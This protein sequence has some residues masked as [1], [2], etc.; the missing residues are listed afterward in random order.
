ML[1][2][3]ATHTQKQ[4]KKEKIFLFSSGDFCAF[5]FDGISFGGGHTALRIVLT[6]YKMAGFLCHTV[7]KKHWFQELHFEKCTLID[8]LSFRN[9][10]PQGI[11]ELG[12]QEK[13]RQLATD[14]LQV[15]THYHYPSFPK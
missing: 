7:L 2:L 4:E 10:N 15:L 3:I 14:G 1:G 9:S 8:I 5:P 11:E 6:I 12:Y 13:N